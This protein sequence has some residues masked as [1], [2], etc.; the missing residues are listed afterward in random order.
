MAGKHTDLMWM[1]GHLIPWDQ[2]NVHCGVI[3]VDRE[4]TAGIDGSGGDV[5]LGARGRRGGEAIALRGI[6][7]R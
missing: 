3:D 2:G 1:D 6:R 7:F 5:E 4:P